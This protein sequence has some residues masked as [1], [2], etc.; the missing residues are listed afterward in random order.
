MFERDCSRDIRSCQQVRVLYVLHYQPAAIT[1]IEKNLFLKAKKKVT[2]APEQIDA[3][4][5]ATEIFIENNY[6]NNGVIIA[7]LLNTVP[8]I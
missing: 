3:G 5:I 6:L 2:R 1:K 8:I 7:C 4:V